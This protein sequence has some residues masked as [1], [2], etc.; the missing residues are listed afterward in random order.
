MS[1]KGLPPRHSLPTLVNERSAENPTLLRLKG[2]AGRSYPDQILQI[3]I[4]S[5]MLGRAKGAAKHPDLQ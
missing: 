1:R 2:L 4:R 5:D 3:G